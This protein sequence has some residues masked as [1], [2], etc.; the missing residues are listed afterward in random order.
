[1][2]R[3]F[4]EWL[5]AWVRAHLGLRSSIP[6]P[7]RSQPIPKPQFLLGFFENLRLAKCL[8]YVKTTSGSTG[9]ASGVSPGQPE[10]QCGLG[11]SI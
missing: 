9:E 11:F 8:R 5:M 7:S 4:P 6:P 3:T 10:V 1:M 2:V